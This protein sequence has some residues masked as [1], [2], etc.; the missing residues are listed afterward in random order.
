MTGVSSAHPTSDPPVAEVCLLDGFR[1]LADGGEAAL[2]MN[3]QRLVAH[4]GL[5]VRPHRCLVAGTLWPTVTD[6]RAQGSLRSTLWRLEQTYPGLVRSVQG[7]MHLAPEVR[8]DARELVCWARRVLDPAEAVDCHGGPDLASRSELLPGWY[9]DWVLIERERL[10]QLRIHALEA[11]AHKLAREGRFGEALEAAHGA[12]RC[13]PLRE[14]VQRITIRIHLAEGNIA[15][16]L[17]TYDRFAQLLR[18][19]LGLQ[20]SDR[21]TSMVASYRQGRRARAV[22]V[23]GQRPASCGRAFDQRSSGPVTV[24]RSRETAGAQ[25]I[26]HIS[27]DHD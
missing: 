11:L 8:V 5:A 19:Q 25:A 26:G 13:E 22:V 17:R 18:A 20:P 16:A 12:G 4:L 10:H 6:R 27:G 21:L 3:A 15:E 14:S 2:P 1:V 9:E 23:A 7:G 24:R